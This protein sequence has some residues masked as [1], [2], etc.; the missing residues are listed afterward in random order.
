MAQHDNG[1]ES[2]LVTTLELHTVEVCKFKAGAVI[3]ALWLFT[4][5]Q[6]ERLI[7]RLLERRKLRELD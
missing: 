4:V 7:E 2:E 6:R 1:P 3:S 5:E